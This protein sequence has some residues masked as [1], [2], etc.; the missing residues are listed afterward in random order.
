M[1]FKWR[2]QGMETSTDD[3]NLLAP[4]DF[5]KQFGMETAYA[6]VRAQTAAEAGSGEAPKKS[7]QLAS[8]LREEETSGGR[9]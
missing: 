2:L 8:K 3:F 4:S 9:T 5:E 6:Q 7:E 1:L